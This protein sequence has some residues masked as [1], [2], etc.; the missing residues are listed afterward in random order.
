MNGG[1]SP[2]GCDHVTSKPLRPKELLSN[3]ADG[4]EVGMGQESCRPCGAEVTGVEEEETEDG[5]RRPKMKKRP[6]EPTRMEIEEHRVTH[7]PY[8]SWCPECVKARGKEDGH[9]QEE[10]RERGVPRV[11][12]DYWFM[13]DS[14]GSELV[15]VASMKED[16]NKM[17]KA[18]VVPAKGNVDMAAERLVKDME[19]MGLNDKA[20]L[21]SDQ[22]PALLDLVN[23]MVKKR[24]HAVTLKEKA[25]ARDSQS[26]G[27]AERAVQSVEGMTRTLKLNLERNLG[28]HVPCAHPVMMWLVEHSAE[29]LNRYLVG[30]DGKTAYEKLKGKKYR[31]EMYEF[32]IAVLHRHPGK[33]EG[34]RMTARWDDGIWL[35]K[36]V[37]SDEH[38]IASAD[39]KIV[40]C[41]SIT[42]KPESESWNA[43]NIM[44]IKVTPWHLKGYISDKEEKEDETEERH[45][46]V[47]RAED[48]EVPVR[49]M[50]SGGLNPEALVP[51]PV[52]RSS[53]PRDL[54]VKPQHLRDYEYTKGCRKCDA[55]KEGDSSYAS[56]SHSSAC[57]QRIRER[58]EESAA[59]QRELQQGQERQ[60]R[61]LAEEVER[62]DG[63]AKGKR[64]R[65]EVSSEDQGNGPTTT[66]SSSTSGKPTTSTTSPTTPTTSS[67]GDQEES[68][69]TAMETEDDSRT[70]TIKTSITDSGNNMSVDRQSNKRGR[71]EKDDEEEHE[72]PTHFRTTE[73]AGNINSI[74]T[75]DGHDLRGGRS[76]VSRGR[77]LFT[78]ENKRSSKATRY[79]RR[80]E[81]RH[82]SS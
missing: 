51:E 37:G 6:H 29:V 81:H 69:D 40:R 48:P 61:F 26:N 11:H 53:V 72:R 74:Y 16:E 62:V 71:D 25:K 13:R 75:T 70:T 3:E 27:Y 31:G 24:K 28:R 76:E 38:I 4:E 49:E 65:I 1:G 34:G 47:H 80:M 8:R 68:E 12:I 78:S 46:Q 32:G 64:V 20:M 79:E 10:G 44:K 17:F 18:H 57:R 2:Q 56:R 52:I 73:D 19:E 54:Y 58:L 41:R 36:T 5:S 82:W 45:V 30:R 7:L 43:E 42:R 67:S 14:P 60:E 63:E 66:S 9:G 23:A 33:P 59:G 55:M 50:G 39:G 35:G 77:S 15:P 21:K 22:E